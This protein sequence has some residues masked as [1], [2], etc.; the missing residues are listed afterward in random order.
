MLKLRYTVQNVDIE[1]LRYILLH[2]VAASAVLVIVINYYHSSFQQRL[3]DDVPFRLKSAFK[4]TRPLKIA[5]FHQYLR[6][7]TSQP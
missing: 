2:D 5:D 1:R 6:I 7:R 4:V 3:V